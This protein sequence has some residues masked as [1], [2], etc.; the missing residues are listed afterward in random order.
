MSTSTDSFLTRDGWRRQG[1]RVP[2]KACPARIEM[3]LVPGYRTVYRDRHLF[4]REQVVPL[5]QVDAERRS[6]AAAKA[7]ATRLANMIELMRTVELT[8]VRGLTK[9]Q[10]YDLALKTHGGNYLGDPGPFNFSPRK[11]RAAIRHN[12]TNYEAQWR[13]INRGKTGEAAYRILRQ[14]IDALVDEAYPQFAETQ[15]EFAGRDCAVR[16]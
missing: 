8:I 13:K 6:Q 16:A 4:S 2:S 12:L 3:Y 10:I 1:F 11:A 9:E 15:S 14:R 7:V 5:D